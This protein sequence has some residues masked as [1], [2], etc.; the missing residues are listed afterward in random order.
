[1]NTPDTRY[2]IDRI[3]QLSETASCGASSAG[4]VAT[5]SVKPTEESADRFA[6]QV[7]GTEKASHI[8]VLGN[9][10]GDPNHPFQNRLVGADESVIPAKNAAQ[11]AQL[12][13]GKKAVGSISAQDL[14]RYLPGLNINQLTAALNKLKAGTLVAGDY[15]ILGQAFAK[16]LLADESTKARVLQMF[17]RIHEVPGTSALTSTPNTAMQAVAEGT[18]KKPQK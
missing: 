2:L 13:R 5:S 8:N 15:S 17:K 3:N 14:T 9:T 1:M 7:S 6:D 11:A 16:L 18:K 10:K 12:D 4:A